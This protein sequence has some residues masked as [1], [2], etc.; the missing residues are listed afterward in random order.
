[1]NK[2]TILFLFF[3][4]VVKGYCQ[5]F[6]GEI[7]YNNHF[8][9]KMKSYTDEQLGNLIGT[10]QEY[11]IKDGNY[12][13]FLNGMSVTMQLYDNKSNRIYNRTPKSDTLYWFDA[14]MNTDAVTSFEIKRNT[15]K[16]LGYQCDAIIMKTKTGTTTIYYNAKYK[17][18][19]KLYTKH[20]YSNWAFYINQ[21]KS[22]PLKT[23]IETD[24][25]KMESIA[26]EIKPMSLGGEYFNIDIKT[27]VKKSN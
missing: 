18:D 23:I 9:S 8:T 27:P 11:L 17:V 15:E 12:K 10:K 3:F 1:M 26:V 21:T 7:I 24:S 19:S 22:L 14:S 25:F 2:A 13:S 5:N 6:E 20:S 4:T 16:I